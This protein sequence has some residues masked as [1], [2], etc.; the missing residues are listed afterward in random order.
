M[1]LLR[2]Y[3]QHVLGCFRHR[4]GESIFFKYYLIPR[5]RIKQY[6]H[7]RRIR[8]LGKAKIVFLVSSLSM[9]RFQQLYDLLRKDPRFETIIATHPF[10][11]SAEVQNKDIESLLN[12]FTKL[13]ISVL[14]L[15]GKDA[16]GKYLRESVNPDLIF[17]PQQY[18]NL[19]CNDLDHQFFSN[20]LIAYIPYAMVIFREAWLDRNTLNEIAWRLF[21]PSE[22]RKQQAVE[23]QFNGGK[24]IR[25]TGDP[26]VDLFSSPV[27]N[28]EW[29][30][31][32]LTKKRVIWA[33]HFSLQE[34]DI[35]HHNAF[36][37]LYDAMLKIASKYKDSVQFSFK[38]HPR[39]LKS[40]YEMP[41]WGKEKAEEYYTTWEKGDNTQ[42]DTGAYIDLFR[43]S[44]ALI[45][46]CGSFTAEYLFT[47]NPVLYTSAK[48]DS[49]YDS[50]NDFGKEALE[51]HYIADSV[52]GII[53]FIENT[54]LGG[55]DPKK[56][57]RESF[58]L[59]YLCPPDGYSAS[60]N[61]YN[62]ILKGLGFEQ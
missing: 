53:D 25:V 16:P 23:V 43:Q 26:A 11:G 33:P 39:L 55:E 3:G 29:K 40:L 61:I 60:E 21:F 51:A 20:K 59:K 12:H 27:D 37:W 41:G 13:D 38:P 48:I 24:N 30:K 46:N 42:L 9:W 7:V 6:W 10:P 57:E 36:L 18:D 32:S 34:S 62:E 54:V 22:S 4:I 19:F 47:G 2:Q 14:N 56:A 1:S 8:R 28:S 45:H 35:L 5:A 31:Q 49:V 52:A 15:F 44:D 50:L 58:F 17:F